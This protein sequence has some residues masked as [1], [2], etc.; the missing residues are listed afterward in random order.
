MANIKPEY[1]LHLAWDRSSVYAIHA[2][3]QYSFLASGIRLAQ[4]FVENGGKRVLYAG[5]LSEYATSDHPL[6]ETDALDLARTHYAFCKHRLHEIADRYFHASG[7]SFG[8]G[9]ISASYG[10]GDTY[11]NRLMGFLWEAC[12]NDH[13]LVNKGG[14]LLRDFIYIKDVAT[15]LVQFLMSDVEGTV[16]ICTGKATSIKGFVTL[17]AKKVVKEHLLRFREDC[18]EQSPVCVGDNTRLVNE[19]GYVPRYTIEQGLSEIAEEF[20]KVSAKRGTKP[21]S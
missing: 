15:A 8:Y 19:V 9:R 10:L 12:L 16:N 17:F 11:R 2:P 13:V 4:A 21:S 6:K 20:L 5:S 14:S 1:L 3:L 7:V 18:A